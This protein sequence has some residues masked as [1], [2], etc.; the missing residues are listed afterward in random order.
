MESKILPDFQKFLLSRG[1][2]PPKNVPFYAN[3]VNKFLAFSNQQ[4][5]PHQR[6][7][8]AECGKRGCGKSWHCQARIRPYT[9]AQFCNTSF[10]ERSEYQGDTEFTG[11]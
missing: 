7:D 9:Q 11:S 2:A 1:F 6:K 10:N 8:C 4:E 3:W 5:A